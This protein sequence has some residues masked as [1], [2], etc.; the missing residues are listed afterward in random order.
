MATRAEVV[1]KERRHHEESIH[2]IHLRKQIRLSSRFEARRIES[3]HTLRR[4]AKLLYLQTTL[5]KTKDF[6]YLTAQEDSTSSQ[7]GFL[8]TEITSDYSKSTAHK[9]VV[10]SWEISYERYA[11][12]CGVEC[13]DVAHRLPL[14]LVHCVIVLKFGGREDGPLRGRAP[15]LFGQ[16]TVTLRRGDL[17]QLGQGSWFQSQKRQFFDLCEDET[18]YGDLQQTSKTAVKDAASISSQGDP[19]SSDDGSFPT[20]ITYSYLKPV[21]GAVHCAIVLEFID[22]DEGPLVHRVLLQ[23]LNLE[24]QEALETAIMVQGE[25]INLGNEALVLPRACLLR[26]GRGPWY[27]YYKPQYQDLYKEAD[28][29]Y[30]HPRTNSSVHRARRIPDVQPFVTETIKATATHANM[31]RTELYAYMKLGSRSNILR[32]MEYFYDPDAELYRESSEFG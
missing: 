10:V 8:L 19:D 1:I 29:L 28:Q 7:D 27:R 26:F 20:D 12:G 17:I 15:L 6:S 23:R 3:R 9:F 18:Q 4:D 31:A 16:A 13:P 25:V 5:G 2:V 21:G 24:S 14:G 32:A 30:G 22:N 11:A